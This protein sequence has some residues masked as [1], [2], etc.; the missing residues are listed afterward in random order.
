MTFTE[1]LH[2]P[3]AATDP[4][5][6]LTVPL[7]DAAEN[8]PPQVL[9]ATGVPATCKPLGSASLKA[10]PVTA[11]AFGL[12][13]VKLSVEVPP[14]AMLV[15]ANVLL[16]VAEPV[17]VSVAVFLVLPV[18]PW[19]ELIGPVVL[20][21]APAV[22]PVTLT[23]KLQLD[24]MAPTLRLI[25]VALATA[26]KIPPHVLVAF[27]TLATCMP[28]GRE[29]LKA[30]W[31]SGRPKFGLLIWKLSTE[32]PPTAILVGE[33]ALLIVAGLATVS[34]AVLVA[35]LLVLPVPPLVEL[36]VPVGLFLTPAVVPVT[37]TEIEH[38]LLPD[39]PPPERLTEVALAN[40]VKVPPQVLLA[41][42]VRQNCVGRVGQQETGPG[43]A[44]SSIRS[45]KTKPLTTAKA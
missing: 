19:V 44:H 41:P 23:D 36:M 37:F 14:T 18:P 7:A 17:T 34:V 28:L 1:R 4:P 32:I 9:V 24:E 29:S 31:N 3:P 33:N 2:D 42:V 8:V 43:R 26:E 15:G 12:L 30:S 22:V 27:G 45:K 11:D 6:K 13:I 38:E 39:T 10:A 35:V 20:F 5:L 40:A 25:V 21:F 16:M